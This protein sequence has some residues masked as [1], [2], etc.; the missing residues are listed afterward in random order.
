M[1]YE[2]FFFTH[3]LEGDNTVNLQVLQDVCHIMCPGYIQVAKTTKQNWCAL[4]C[5]FR[6]DLRWD[7]LM[8]RVRLH[9]LALQKI[10][11]P[12]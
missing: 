7:L 4:N 2:A 6:N 11:V 10:R 12:L 9:I 5:V 3:C 1:E 8:L